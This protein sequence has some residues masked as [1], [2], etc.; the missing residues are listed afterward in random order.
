MVSNKFKSIRPLLAAAALSVSVFAAVPVQAQVSGLEIVA[1]AS[2]GG[3]WDQHARAL[4]QALMTKNLATGVQVVNVPGAGGTIGLAQF[5]TAKK[6]NPSL[7]I[8]GQIMQGA[9]LTNKSP[10][11]LDQ[12]TPL[13]R[14]TGEYTA[15]VVPTDSPVQS[16]Q[17]LIGK[18]KTDPGSVSWGGG[19]AG[20][21]DQILAGLIAKEVG[22]EPARINYVATA[23][24]GELMAQILGGHITVAMGGYNE[25]APQIKDGKLRAVALSAPE[26]L[27][28]VAAPT[29]KEQGVNLDFINW[30]GVFAKPGLKATEKKQLE[31][32]VAAVVASSEWKETLR[33]RGWLDLYQP[34]G[35]FA[36]YLNAEQVRVKE[37]LESIGLIKG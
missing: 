9:I 18:F 15:L 33:Q 35:E 26:R 24:G 36:A 19:S 7:L 34:S 20:G 11:T 32:M 6:R 8:G 23:G 17:D 5:V 22:V 3:G 30:R 2:P 21:S 25:F 31:D 29:L 37:T 28:D 10:V 12:V 14:L 13:A 16:L 27:P 1:P 4:Q